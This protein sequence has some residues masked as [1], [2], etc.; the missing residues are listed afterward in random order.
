MQSLLHRVFWGIVLVGA[1][2]IFL[3]N[4][5]GVI[6]ID[7]GDVFKT[8]WP[9]ILL[10]VGI[11]GMLLQR[12]GGQWWNAILILLALYFLA[13]NLDWVEWEFHDLIRFVGPI[14]LIVFGLYMIA[15][16]GRTKKK[17]S[18]EAEWN[19]INPPPMS[20]PPP[21]APP[22]EPSIDR[23]PPPAPEPLDLGFDPSEP[24]FEEIP[25]QDPRPRD[26]SHMK[27]KYWKEHH[28]ESRWDGGYWDHSPKRENHSRFIGDFDIGSD[29]FE[30]RPMSISNF[31]G[32]T[33]LDLTRAQIPAGET[34]I[35]VSSF[36]G[37]VKVF[38]P[39]DFSVGVRVVSSSFIG[40]VAV[41][42]QKRDGF[43][44][45]VNLQTPNFE[46]TAKR[47]VIIVSTF[48]GDVRI[49]KVG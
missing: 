20:P 16:G 17:P 21:P 18:E 9:V 29:Y 39:N 3:L 24:K 12:N 45:Q 1:G 34:K 33:R 11:Q 15:R 23:G 38:I 6:S 26:G 2:V 4:Q 37:D 8:F 28:Q 22:S 47:I 5:A 13:R 7:I 43:F 25:E 40:D 30:L 42:E 49:K 36:I 27:H 44:N 32:D 31:I 10:L 41:L 48:I 14:A 19:T 46:D 35:Y